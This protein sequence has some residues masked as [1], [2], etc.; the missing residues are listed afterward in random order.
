L[1]ELTAPRF[2]FAAGGTGYV[3]RRLIPALLARGHR[4]RA[5]ARPGSEGKLPEACE[6]VAGDALDAATFAPRV[7]PCDTFVQ[8]VGVAHPSPAK[9][10]QFR[11]VDLASVRA[12]AQAAAAS[13]VRHF[14][15][16][17]VARPAPVMKEYQEVRAEGERIVRETGIAATF[18]RPWYVLGP[19]HRWPA[20]LVPVYWL[21]ERIPSTRDAARRLGLVRLPAM[22][23]A[24]VAAVEN[25]PAGVRVLEVPDIR[26]AA[27]SDS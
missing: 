21:L 26:A 15:Y 22:V 7:A 3:G 8:L 10:A 13:G 27:S 19:G 9:A 24:L 14:V 11:T 16:V 1:S 23:R 18:L 6:R 17:S 12:S 2:V 4:V 5:L 20:A 25:P